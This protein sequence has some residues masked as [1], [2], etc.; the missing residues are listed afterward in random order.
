MRNFWRS[1]PD[2]HGLVTLKK[3]GATRGDYKI[4][5]V[6][7]SD[8]I[9][10]WSDFTIEILGVKF[11]EEP[12]MP[13]S[14]QFFS[15]GKESEYDCAGRTS[16][17][18]WYLFSIYRITHKKSDIAIDVHWWPEHGRVITIQDLPA[19]G[20]TNTDLEI[21]NEALKLFRVETRGG[22]KITEER[23]KQVIAESGSSVSQKEAARM[24]EVT[25]SGLEKWRARRGFSTWQEVVDRM[26]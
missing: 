11:D 22:V 25:E 9:E 15:L 5:T 4:I 1:N 8:L 3:R 16:K 20:P 17:V 21:I 10:Q 12:P 7:G 26:A 24:L 14:D 13:P 2:E 23:I 19:A 6:T 18:N